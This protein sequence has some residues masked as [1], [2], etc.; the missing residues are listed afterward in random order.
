M[1]GDKSTLKQ[2]LQSPLAYEDL[3]LIPKRK[4]PEVTSA[5]AWIPFAMLFDWNT[6]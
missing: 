4:M 2:G 3:P 5:G 6:S 1:F